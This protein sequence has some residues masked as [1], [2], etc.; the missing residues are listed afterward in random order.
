MATKIT[1]LLPIP[2]GTHEPHAYQVF[3]LEPGEQDSAVIAK[4]VKA[5]VTRLKSVK[6]S[7]DA[8]LWATAAQI[9]QQARVTL[10]D[11]AKKSQLD[12]RFGII[13]IPDEPQAPPPAADAS[14]SDPLAG[15]LPS[16]DPLAALLPTSNPLAPA[17]QTPPPSTDVTNAQPQ[18]DAPAMPAGVFGAAEP[19]VTPAV[20]TPVV[21]RQPTVQRR[22]RS[23]LGTLL[24]MSFTLGMIALIGI[25]GYFLLYGP[26]QVAITKSNEGLSIS[27]QPAP[28]PAESK[29]PIAAEPREAPREPDLVMGNLGGN[30][31]PPPRRSL[32]EPVETN[33]PE[34]PGEMSNEPQMEPEPPATEPPP[35]SPTPAPASLTDEMIAAATESIGR[36]R[37]LIQG[38]K[39]S[40]MKTAAEATLEMPMQPP[41]KAEAE[42]LFEIADLA[43]YYREGINRAVQDLNV[44]NDF[45]VTDSFRVIVV[46][47]GEDLLI[48][49]YNEKNRSF[50]FDEFPFSLAHKLASFS[51]PDNATTKAAKA[52]YQAI[53]PKGTQAHREES[54]SWLREITEEVEGAD[55]QRI[56]DVLEQMFAG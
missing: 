10:A 50:T 29:I 45:A 27:T 20:N 14:A 11:P 19:E 23:I 15:M 1:D 18:V 12:A 4:A 17:D 40:E 8:K 53:A 56:A 9:V 37:S 49:R 2:E 7:T 39:W 46:E 44:G 31:V 5:T 25:L 48:V 6:E 47:K 43:T 42:T 26:G 21:V 24:F 52:V 16:A 3:G 54:V 38:G 22:K 35:P 51:V 28:S 13:A 41:Q 36:T 30:S 34:D 33:P 55:P 32:N